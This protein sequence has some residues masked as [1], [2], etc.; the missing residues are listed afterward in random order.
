MDI[1]DPRALSLMHLLSLL[2]EIANPPSH[3][4]LENVRGFEDSRAHERL[5]EVIGWMSQFYLAQIYLRRWS[6]AAFVDMPGS[7]SNHRALLSLT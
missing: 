3:F 5:L 4:F 6:S 2:E 1:E 7:L